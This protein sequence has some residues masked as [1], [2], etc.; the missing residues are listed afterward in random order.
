MSTENTTKIVVLGA[1]PIGLEAALYAR[2]LGYDVEVFERGDVANN[3]SDWGHVRMFSPF[4]ANASTLGLAAISAQQ[5]DVQP[6]AGGELLT[7]QEFRERYLIPLAQ[8]DLLS[9]HV[10]THTN[11]VAVAREGF[12]KNESVGAETRANSKFSILTEDA[13]GGES[14]HEA[15]VV[16]DSTGTW[17]QPRWLGPSGLPAIG[18]RTHRSSIEYH[19]PD[20]QVE[21]SQYGD[22]H[23]LVVGSGYSAATTVVALA[24]LAST[25]PE[26]RITWVTRRRDQLPITVIED[27]PLQE[28]RELTDAANALASQHPP[29]THLSGFSVTAVEKTDDDRLS[30]QLIG[31]DQQT[32]QV[33]RIIANVGFKPHMAMLSEL[34]LHSCYA[35]EGPMKLAALLLSSSATDCL[36]QPKTQAE[37]L[38]T[39]EANF[40]ILGSKSYGRN[41]QFLLS[42]GLTQIQ[43]L[44]TVIAGREELNLYSSIEHSA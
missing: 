36:R 44:F 10:H 14:Y 31:Q 33:D 39:T 20:V 32:I 13:D 8:S 5:D 17:N 43:E 7:G 22:R 37:S 15:D 21:A 16:I 42:A 2:F 38:M 19:V 41:S 34:Q 24:D 1:G 3:V 4:S 30:V 40:Y 9:D 26:T 27:D 29:V 6:P 12:L 35:T 28:R 11:V 18:E 23:T 25:F